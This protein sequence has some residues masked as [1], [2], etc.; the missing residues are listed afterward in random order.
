M[1]APAT[2]LQ[3][4]T[5]ILEE[6]GAPVRPVL[7]AVEAA[8]ERSL[9]M[10][11]SALSPR[12]TLLFPY[13]PEILAELAPGVSPGLLPSRPMLKLFIDGDQ[14]HVA[15]A[16]IGKVA[17]SE[18]VDVAPE[19]TRDAWV[20]AVSAM[21]GFADG[22][23]SSRIRFLT[24]PRSTIDVFY[25][26]RAQDVDAR[27]TAGMDQVAW[28]VG[29]APSQREGWKSVH[30]SLGGV[31]VTVTTACTDGGPAPELAFMYGIADWDEAV[32]A[33]TLVAG[34]DAARGGAAML[35]MLAATLEAEQMRSLQLA[36]R[37]GGPDVGALV[38][39]K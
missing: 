30:S 28:R 13:R 33:C 2:Q 25:Q 9:C 39:L 6:R 1:S 32:R 4:L 24:Q 17:P 8:R 16:A 11:V 19:A 31:A 14:L 29:V 35:G 36:L 10:E 23:I 3:R 26:A 34:E 12:M 22:R 37:P 15:L 27:F 20:D 38:M 21:H 18:A 7:R 5:R